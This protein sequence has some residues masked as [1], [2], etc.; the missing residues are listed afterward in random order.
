MWKNLTKTKKTF[1]TISFSSQQACLQSV[2][3]TRKNYEA[4]SKKNWKTLNFKKD[5]YLLKTFFSTNEEQFLGSW[6]KLSEKNP[7]NFCIMSVKN[8]T[9]GKFFLKSCSQ[10]TP[11]EMAKAVFTTLVKISAQGFKKYIAE[12]RKSTEKS[13][14]SRNKIENSE[15]SSGELEGSFKNPGNKFS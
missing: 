14:P 15:Q 5:F 10:Q 11:L 3:V 13:L 12:S 6:P 7:K 8:P 9:K 4:D 2:V 1:L